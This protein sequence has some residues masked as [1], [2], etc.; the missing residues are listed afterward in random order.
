MPAVPSA[1][2]GPGTKECVSITGAGAGSRPRSGCPLGLY[3]L[4]LLRTPYGTRVSSPTTVLAVCGHDGFAAWNDPRGLPLGSA[5][6]PRADP[7][8]SPVGRLGSGS[9]RLPRS[10]VALQSQSRGP[11]FAALPALPAPSPG[12]PWTPPQ[13]APGLGHQP[14]FCGPTFPPLPVE[15]K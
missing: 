7:S 2:P 11:A 14:P 8:V 12:L 4:L 1:G 15:V 10:G 6:P 13:H 9:L 3:S 5:E